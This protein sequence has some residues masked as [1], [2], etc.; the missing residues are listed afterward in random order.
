MASS[1]KRTWPWV[2]TAVVLIAGAVLT[3]LLEGWPSAAS[4]GDFVAGFASAL[5]FI[6]L[7]AGYHQQGDE[8]ALQRE[9][10]RATRESLD[11][12]KQE[13][14]RMTSHASLGQ[15]NAMLL[16]FGGRLTAQGIPGLNT[17]EDIVHKLMDRFD[18]LGRASRAH[19]METS[20]NEYTSWRHV[21]GIARRFLMTIKMGAEMYAR[22]VE[23]VAMVAEPEPEK[24][25]LA[26]DSVLRAMPHISEC[27]HAGHVLAYVLDQIAPWRKRAYERYIG[28][29]AK[30]APGATPDTELQAAMAARIRTFAKE[31][32]I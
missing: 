14:H 2:L 29:V 21:E 23:G 1:R 13:L 4:V 20:I 3:F 19:D 26:N 17:Y 30:L 6:W 31:N 15:I 27:M 18:N 16:D 22:D 9:E 32:P 12:Q 7:I 10:L 11:L 28:A 25:V 5:A 8:L 24:F